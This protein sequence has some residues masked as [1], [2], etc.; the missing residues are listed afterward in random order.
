[1]IRANSRYSSEGH[2]LI[3]KNDSNV[4]NEIDNMVDEKSNQTIPELEEN[5]I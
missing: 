5:D 4:F 3:Q 1:M 2:K